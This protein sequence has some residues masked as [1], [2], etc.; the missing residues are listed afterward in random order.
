MI[1]GAAFLAYAGLIILLVAIFTWLADEIGP[2][3]SGLVVTAATL[4]IAFIL[5]RM[6]MGRINA[7][8][9]AISGGRT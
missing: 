8:K 7:A 9:T 4:L 6:G 5:F 1:V 2:I 3:G